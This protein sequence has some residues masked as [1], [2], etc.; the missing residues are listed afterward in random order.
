MDNEIAAA[1]KQNGATIVN[2]RDL[3]YFQDLEGVLA[4]SSYLELVI[5]T[6]TTAYCLGTASGVVTWQLQWRLA[7]TALGDD[8][9]CGWPRVW[10]FVREPSET[11]SQPVATTAAALRIWARDSRRS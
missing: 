7:Y 8:A 10:G 9:H 3:D 1:Q 6:V 11:R 2:V 5:S 4:L